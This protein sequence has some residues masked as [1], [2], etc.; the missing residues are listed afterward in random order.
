MSCYYA[1]QAAA[2]GVRR[3]DC[4]EPTAAFTTA[5]ERTRALNHFSDGFRV[6]NKAVVA[7]DAPV[8]S[9]H[10]PF[11]YNPCRI[12][13][14]IEPATIPAVPFSEVLRAAAQPITLLKIDIDSIDGVLLHEVVRAIRKGEL[15][16][17]T[18]VI[19]LGGFS[20]AGNLDSWQLHATAKKTR[21]PLRLVANR[22]G[23]L[24]PRGGH[25]RDLYELQHSLGYE[26]YRVN[27]HVGREIFDWRGRNVNKQ[28]TPEL[29]GVETHFSVRTMRK[30]ERVL[31]SMPLADYATL[32]TW[33]ASFLI[34][35]VQLAEA[36]RHH[37]FDNSRAGLG[38]GSAGLSRLNRGNPV[39][40]GRGRIT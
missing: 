21:R 16:V 34:T 13:K 10:M 25:V 11:A 2:L 18:M 26:L 1:A 35:R 17:E 37:V 5:I 19:E 27:I 6:H 7:S 20:G 31:P 36:A 15:A 33:G 30:L 22:S 24:R 8:S 3:V 23:L 12:S 38:E 14:R 9:V 40:G 4:Y 39:I 32:V 28:M 29:P